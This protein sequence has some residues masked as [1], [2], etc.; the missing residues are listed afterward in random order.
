MASGDRT[1]LA[2]MCPVGGHQSGKLLTKINKYCT[3]KHRWSSKLH[4]QRHL[5]CDRS[6]SLD[7]RADSPSAFIS[8]TCC[9]IHEEAPSIHRDH[10]ALLQYGNI[11]RD[12]PRVHRMPLEPGELDM[13]TDL[14]IIKFRGRCHTISTRSGFRQIRPF[15]GAIRECHIHAS[16]H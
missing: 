7:R 11:A 6:W 2:K 5:N 3:V 1:V 10:A 13:K 8:C 15:Y 16:C 12:T 9:V 14:L 4:L